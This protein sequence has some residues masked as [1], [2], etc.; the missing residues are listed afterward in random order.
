MESS[1]LGK[2]WLPNMGHTQ[3]WRIHSLAWAKARMLIASYSCSLFISILDRI[4][5]GIYT[6]VATCKCTYDCT[7]SCLQA[8]SYSI[9]LA[10]WRELFETIKDLY[11]YRYTTDVYILYLCVYIKAVY[12]SFILATLRNFWSKSAGCVN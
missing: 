5:N 8:T 7:F 1:I 10:D 3:I 2:F 6:V 4:L 12:L 11:K 9:G